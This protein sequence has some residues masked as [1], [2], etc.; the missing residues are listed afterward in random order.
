MAVETDPNKPDPNK[1]TLDLSNPA[2]KAAFDAAVE[3]AVQPLKANRDEILGEKRT[4]TEKLTKLTEQQ[5]AWGDLD[6]AKVRQIMTVFSQNEEA[7]LIADGKIDEVMNRRTDAM[8]RDADARV[9][10]AQGK[11]EELT[12]TIAGLEGKISTLVIDAEVR[13]A[14]IKLGILPSA[15]DDAILRA[16]QVFKLDKEHKPEARDPNGTI[17]LG[18]NGKDPLSPAEWLEGLKTTSPHWWGANSGGGAGGGSGVPS[19]NGKL[20]A[21]QINQMTPTQK[22]AHVLTGGAGE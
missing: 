18:K 21:D 19:G 1:P 9:T 10:A 17:R 11:A 15:V 20:S 8:R 2:T 13:T 16:R 5:A 7:K 6:P 3:A 12:K 22:F 14:A 4:L